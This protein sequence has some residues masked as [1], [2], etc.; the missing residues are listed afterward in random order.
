[1]PGRM[2]QPRL[3]GSPGKA[4]VLRGGSWNNNQDNARTS[5]RNRNNPNNRNTPGVALRNNVGFRVVVLPTSESPFQRPQGRRP[6]G[7]LAGSITIQLPK[8]PAFK[9][10]GTRRK[11]REGAGWSRPHAHLRVGQI[12]K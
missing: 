6:A 3:A 4:R 8:R 5:N 10:S 2:Q 7:G 9:D 11:S 1:M 12:Y